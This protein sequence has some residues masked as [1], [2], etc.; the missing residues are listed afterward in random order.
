F[1]AKPRQR[2]YGNDAITGDWARLM[3]RLG[4][5]R[6][7]TQGTDI[8]AGIATQLAIDDRAHVVGLHL[9]VCG[10]S[11]PAAA[12]SAA[13]CGHDLLGHRQRRIIGANLL[14]TT[15]STGR[16]PNPR[17]RPD[18][19]RELQRAIRQTSGGRL[20]QQRRNAFQHRPME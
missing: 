17:D 19:M 10:G 12:G 18:W 16:T 14:R 1:S 13:H 2:G 7:G 8:G 6:Y 9:T 11:P 3:A 15:P 4:Y 5:S 20:T